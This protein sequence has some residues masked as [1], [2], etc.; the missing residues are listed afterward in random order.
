[1]KFNY[2]VGNPPYLRGMHLKIT[3]RCYDILNPKGEFIFI[4]PA[5]G[6]FN[7]TSTPDTTL[8]RYRDILQNNKVKMKIVSGVTAFGAGMFL[9]DLA[10]TKISKTPGGIQ[11]QYKNGDT[12]QCELKDINF[13]QMPPEIFAS[14]RE[15][16]QLMIQKYGEL[17]ELRCCDVS[18]GCS[19]IPIPK[20]RGNVNQE[21]GYI[22]SNF[23]SFYSPIDY[24]KKYVEVK[25][26]EDGCVLVCR[27]DEAEYLYQYLS[28]KTAQVA[29]G[30]YK[31]S[32]QT[33]N[34]KIPRLPQAF[35]EMLTDTQLFEMFG[36]TEEEQAWIQKVIPD[37]DPRVKEKMEDWV[38]SKP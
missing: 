3:N 15:K 37:Y 11:V 29:G 2:I 31:Y 23:Y 9:T 13:L 38:V 12:Y 7:K 1:M 5:A 14:I 24:R 21:T 6:I 10:I 32:S 8:K 16:I 36:F 33:I 19:G 20:V 4:Q 27:E 34:F 17:K 18:K 35:K 25:E 28:T 22:Q 30:M 26:Y